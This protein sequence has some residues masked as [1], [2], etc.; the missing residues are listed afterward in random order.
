MVGQRPCELGRSAM[1]AETTTKRA[2][3]ARRLARRMETIDV[4][5]VHPQ[6]LFRE[7]LAQVLQEEERVTLVGA[8]ASNATA[9]EQIVAA[10]PAIVLL[11][12][13]APGGTAEEAVEDI[14]RR[15]PGTRVMI[16]TPS[17]DPSLLERFARLGV[18]AYVT[19]SVTCSDFLAA[20]FTVCRDQG[21][22]LLCG[23]KEMFDRLGGQKGKAPLSGREMEVVHS[24]SQG[25]TNRAIAR[26]LHITEGTVKRHLANIFRKLDVCSR[27]DL[28]RVAVGRGWVNAQEFGQLDEAR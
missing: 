25:L 3:P 24:V 10:R 11:H 8:A 19:N 13:D 22:M 26:E 6:P 28:V 15:S 16:L 14:H 5:L 9:V 7:S 4:F 21:Q 27:L 12:V 23:P 18:S 2:A 20:M 1:S 17:E